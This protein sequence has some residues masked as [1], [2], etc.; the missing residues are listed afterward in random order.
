MLCYPLCDF[1]G[2]EEVKDEADYFRE[3]STDSTL[4][5][6]NRQTISKTEQCHNSTPVDLAIFEQPTTEKFV[7]LWAL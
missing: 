1:V 5:N 3:K 2:N 4:D 7:L 6:G